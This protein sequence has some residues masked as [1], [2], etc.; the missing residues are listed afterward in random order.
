MLAS[1]KS[2][3]HQKAG[4][5]ALAEYYRSR[6]NTAHSVLEQEAILYM[7]SLLSLYDWDAQDN[8]ERK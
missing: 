6:L 5:T 8:Q 1:I 3:I 4:G 2:I 7:S